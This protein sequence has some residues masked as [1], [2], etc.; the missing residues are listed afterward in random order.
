MVMGWDGLYYFEYTATFPRYQPPNELA[1]VD[2]LKNARVF[3][4]ARYGAP[5]LVDLDDDGDL[6]LVFGE[7]SCVDV[8]TTATGLFSSPT[9]PPLS[10]HALARAGRR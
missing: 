10:R 4:N 5:A 9:R 7:N 6:D 3:Q 8:S 2:E 1:W